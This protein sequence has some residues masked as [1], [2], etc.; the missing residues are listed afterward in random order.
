MHL[1]PINPAAARRLV[2]VSAQIEAGQHIPITST[3]LE[4]RKRSAEARTHMRSVAINAVRAAG[5]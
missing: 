1:L 4:C 3:G 2:T 5:C